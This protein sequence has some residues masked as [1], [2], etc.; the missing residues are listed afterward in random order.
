MSSS[1]EYPIITS[2]CPRLAESMDNR[3]RYGRDASQ[4]RSKDIFLS[5]VHFINVRQTPDIRQ[6]T[7]FECPKHTYV[8]FSNA[9]D[10]LKA[11]CTLDAD[12]IDKLN[13]SKITSVLAT[14]IVHGFIL[15][16]AYVSVYA[17]M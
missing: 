7:S 13:A 10:T 4:I 16:Q 17:D 12:M 8:R 3:S 15:C 6:Y 1:V 2:T 5:S 11:R 9:L 14:Y